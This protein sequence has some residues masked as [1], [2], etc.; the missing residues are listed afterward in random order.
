MRYARWTL[1]L[2]VALHALALT[3]CG[4]QN[5]GELNAG[6]DLEVRNLEVSPERTEALVEA[7]NSLLAPG[8][9]GSASVAG[10]GQ[11][12]VRADPSTLQQIESSF[13]RM[14]AAYEQSQPERDSNHRVRL[15]A[16]ALKAGE[17]LEALPT[18][19]PD[20]KQALA[21]LPYSD[22]RQLEASVQSLSADGREWRSS[23]VNLNISAGISRMGDGYLAELSL[24]SNRREGAKASESLAHIGAD[25]RLAMKPGEYVL[26][27][28]R[29]ESGGG[30]ALVVRIEPIDPAP[31]Q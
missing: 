25:G 18:A 30:E 11:V 28:F 26:M 24:M 20:I 19:S 31:A 23:G 14:T 27:S 16:W 3:G 12:L 17:G 2:I 6:T 13:E 5:A 4:Q 29:D 22:W 15:Q 21:G 8:A 1:A 7:L 10:P 9:A